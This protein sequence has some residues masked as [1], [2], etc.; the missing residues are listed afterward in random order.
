MVRG[1]LASAINVQAQE[2]K[3]K[4][5]NET[6]QGL[7]HVLM[8]SCSLKPPLV[9][10]LPIHL[11]GLPIL[12]ELPIL[13]NLST[14]KECFNCQYK[15]KEVQLHF[16]VH[17]KAMLDPFKSRFRI[18]WNFLPLSLTVCL[19]SGNSCGALQYEVLLHVHFRS[20]KQSLN[21]LAHGKPRQNLTIGGKV[22]WEPTLWPKRLFKDAKAWA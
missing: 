18:Y 2:K 15:S 8:V 5:R 11:W 20:W 4:T 7:V 10:S 1:S 16:L 21:S 17:G 3:K 13:V 14:A 12:P 22:C 6:A 9:D 19:Y